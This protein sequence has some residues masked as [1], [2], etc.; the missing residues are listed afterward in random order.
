MWNTSFSHP[1]GTLAEPGSSVQRASQAPLHHV[2][3]SSHKITLP[4]IKF[5]KNKQAWWDCYIYSLKLALQ[6][7]RWMG[8]DR[9][10]WHK[11]D[12]GKMLASWTA[13]HSVPGIGQLTARPMLPI[14]PCTALLCCPTHSSSMCLSKPKW[15]LPKAWV[16]CCASAGPHCAAHLLGSHTSVCK[17]WKPSLT[18]LILFWLLRFSQI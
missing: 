13:A 17:K 6:Q 14:L 1:S 12:Q 16:L 15:E 5:I 11:W 3:F 7:A 4:T 10:R 8:T 2:G 9:K 18:N